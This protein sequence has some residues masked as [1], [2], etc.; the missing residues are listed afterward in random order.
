MLKRLSAASDVATLLIL[1]ALGLAAK[2]AWQSGFDPLRVGALISVAP[3]VGALVLLLCLMAVPA[4]FEP[5]RFTWREAITMPVIHGALTLMVTKMIS[6]KSHAVVATQEALVPI[7]HWLNPAA[8]AWMVG[9]ELAAL[10]ALA[11][12]RSR[13]G[14]E[15]VS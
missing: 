14:G 9:I 13:N 4:L 2:E 5:G 11:A 8:L 15:P 10:G 12:L 3:I 1:V 7:E 6:T